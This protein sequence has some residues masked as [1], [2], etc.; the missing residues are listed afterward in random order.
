[1]FDLRLPGQIKGQ[2]DNRTLNRRFR[3]EYAA[4][5]TKQQ[6]GARIQLR[7]DAGYAVRLGLWQSHKPLGYLPLHHEYGFRQGMAMAEKP[8]KDGARYVVGQ[9][10]MTCSGPLEDWTN[11]GQSNF[12]ASARRTSRSGCAALRYATARGSTSS[13][14]SCGKRPSSSPVSAPGSWPNLDHRSAG[15]SCKRPGNLRGRVGI[16]QKVLP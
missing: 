10:S 4:R 11:P 12:R 5:D 13:A 8:E 15:R 9:V 2:S 6:P 7:Q 3:P 1:M 16:H 14:T